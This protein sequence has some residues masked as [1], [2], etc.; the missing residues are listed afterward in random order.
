MNWKVF[1]VLV[2]AL[3]VLSFW[4][5]YF[6]SP[7]GSVTFFAPAIT[8]GNAGELVPFSLAV[9]PGFGR[10]FVNVENSEFASSVQQ[11]FLLAREEAETILGV[12]FHNYDFY[13]TVDAS[14]GSV[15]GESAGALFTSA[16]VSVF[17]GKP[18]NSSVEVS[19]MLAD[20]GSL[21]PVDGIDEKILAAYTAGKNVFV[22]SSQQVI[23]YESSLPSGVRIVRVDNVSSAV[24]M[25]LS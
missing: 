2:F 16:I 13:L 22:V 24:G 7:S 23:P 5:G 21:L 3:A 25:M 12:D 6:S 15:S 1:L 4:E 17:T 19:A 8:S 18:L 9:K 11:S 20:N 10:V 14:G